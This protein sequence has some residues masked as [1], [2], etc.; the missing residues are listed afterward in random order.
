MGGR[1]IAGIGTGIAGGAATGAAFGG[2]VGAAIGGGVGGL[3]SGLSQLLQQSDEAKQRERLRQQLQ[4]QANSQMYSEAFD[5]MGGNKYP[6]LRA[7]MWD[8]TSP[9]DV[10]RMVADR[11]QEQE[12]DWGAFLQSIAGAA[13]AVRSGARADAFEQELERRRQNFQVGGG[14][15]S[16]GGYWGGGR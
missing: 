15:G 3:L 10:E 4:E 14:N 8:P 5:L 16:L 11:T 13:G 12:P 6:G 9:Q 7:A 1:A 2:P